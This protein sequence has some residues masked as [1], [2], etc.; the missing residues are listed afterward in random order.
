M[1]DWKWQLLSIIFIPLAIFGTLWIGVG[2]F[3]GFVILPLTWHFLLFM[4]GI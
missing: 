1:T 3:I 2:F 4:L